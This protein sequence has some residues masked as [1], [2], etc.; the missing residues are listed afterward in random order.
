MA[1]S[2]PKYM[3]LA[4]SALQS[5]EG[6]SMHRTVKS[7]SRATPVKLTVIFVKTI[8]FLS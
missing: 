7:R 5:N 2:V 8:V 4:I 6:G 1:S 3:E